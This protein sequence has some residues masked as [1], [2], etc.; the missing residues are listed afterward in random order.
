MIFYLTTKS[1]VK[2]QERLLGDMKDL[3]SSVNT[4]VE[5]RT[6]EVSSMVAA[7]LRKVHAIAEQLQNLDV[8]L[9]KMRPIL[10]ERAAGLPSQVE[11]KQMED[12]LSA[13]LRTMLDKLSTIE[14]KAKLQ[15]RR[16]HHR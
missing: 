4:V 15:A 13:K 1:L 6:A 7:P 12:R 16:I 8:Q 10:R 3:E 11:L 2:L 14:G 9:G 5:Q